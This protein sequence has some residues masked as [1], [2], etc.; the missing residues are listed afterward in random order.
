[1]PDEEHVSTTEDETLTGAAGADTFVFGRD[2]GADVVAGFTN[3]EDLIDL[4]AFSTLLHMAAA[5]SGLT[6]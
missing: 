3:G 1:M 5:R 6:T 2:N 4:S